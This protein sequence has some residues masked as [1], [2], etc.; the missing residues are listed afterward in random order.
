MAP[1]AVNVAVWPGQIVGELTVIFKF[2]AT[3]TVA[4]AVP[5]QP[6]EIP[7]TVY[8]VVELGDTVI[9]FVLSPLLQE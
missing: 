1:L 5:V 4:I 7:V 2:G 6:P 3:V 9:G 8:D